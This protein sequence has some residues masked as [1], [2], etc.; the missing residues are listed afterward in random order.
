ML[1]SVRFVPTWKLWPLRALWVPVAFVPNWN[2]DLSLERP[3]CCLSGPQQIWIGPSEKFVPNFIKNDQQP[4]K[5]KAKT[6]RG[7]RSPKNRC[8]AF[9]SFSLAVQSKYAFKFCS[10]VVC[11]AGEPEG[12]KGLKTH[13]I[14]VVQEAQH[15]SPLNII[16]W[17]PEL[18]DGMWCVQPFLYHRT[19]HRR[20]I[21]PGEHSTGGH[22]WQYW[23][24]LVCSLL[25]LVVGPMEK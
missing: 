14:V 8:Q 22:T 12:Y 18:C 25:L 15:W 5:G 7:D 10:V 23:P 2:L 3:V 9:T 1:H 4:R 24:S 13:I 16:T 19:G 17:E 6:K 21:M 20:C 11:H